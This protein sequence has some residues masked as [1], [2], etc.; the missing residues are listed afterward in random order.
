MSVILDDYKKKVLPTLSDDELAKL[1]IVT[2][3][4]SLGGGTKTPTEVQ[5][6]LDWME[7]RTATE[8]AIGW[9]WRRRSAEISQAAR[10]QPDQLRRRLQAC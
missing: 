4:Q 3:E 8:S 1:R 2:H 10:W 5:V 9:G 7:A 6:A